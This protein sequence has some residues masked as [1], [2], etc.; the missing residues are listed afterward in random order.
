[1][2][3]RRTS[4]H[5]RA[6]RARWVEGARRLLPQAVHRAARRAAWV[7]A[8]VGLVTVAA[9]SSTVAGKGQIDPLAA[10]APT[11]GTGDPTASPP[12]ATSGPSSSPS[13]VPQPTGPTTPLT[14]RAARFEAPAG[15]RLSTSNWFS[16][17]VRVGEQ[18]GEC[19]LRIVDVPAAHAAK[20]AVATPDPKA[21]QGW[22]VGIG[23]PMCNPSQN[24]AVTASQ[25]LGTSFVKMKNK[26]AAQGTWQVHCSNPQFDFTPRVWWLPKTQLAFIEN[27]SG[28]AAVDA[29][30]D[31]I[32]ASV[33][34]AGE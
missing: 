4:S 9:C 10:P 25:S 18:P 30:V 8:L 12:D 2:R 33:T 13:A 27:H 15:W 16:C 24:V 31:R 19:T 34:I 21:P 32:I 17:L 22:W 11:D 1:M 7:A 14:F 20:Q 5:R 28:D 6:P 26:T 29:Q 23:P 3:V